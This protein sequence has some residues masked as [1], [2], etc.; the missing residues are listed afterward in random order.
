MKGEASSL[1]GQLSNGTAS[2]TCVGSMLVYKT[3]LNK[4]L[5]NLVWSHS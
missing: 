5:S 1:Q 2:Q 4:V 3:R